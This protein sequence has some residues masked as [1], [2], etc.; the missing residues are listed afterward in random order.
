[1]DTL[2]NPDSLPPWYLLL[3]IFGIAF[4]YSSVGFG[5]AS[6]YLAAMSFFVLSPQ[7]MA[8]TALSLN[9]LVASIAFATYWRT[10]YFQRSLLLPFVAAS[11]PA[12]F[13]GGYIR[14]SDEVYFIILYVALAYLGIRLLF[15]GRFQREALSDAGDATMQPTL[16]AVLASGLLIGG[17]S[18]MVGLGGGIF[19]SPLIIL[20]GWGSPKEAAATSAGFI[21]ANSLS[22]L[23]GR[24]ISGNLAFGL[25]GLALLPVGILGAM[26]GS[27]LGARYLSGQTLRIVLG[28]VLL[29]AVLRFVVG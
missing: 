8:T 19:L 6:G 24:A 12:A 16:V 14:I 11:V 27:N 7:F 2:L 15:S 5:G 18:G 4:L 3:F 29:L 25:L 28:S 13:F 1:M 20:A 21:V 17:L 26:L 22:G 9:V 23:V 10:G